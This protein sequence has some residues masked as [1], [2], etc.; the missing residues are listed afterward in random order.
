[1]GK[2]MTGAERSMSLNEYEVVLNPNDPHFNFSLQ[3]V[4]NFG[5][6]RSR[7]FRAGLFI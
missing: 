6:A 4:T 2:A 5:S 3:P 1:V 7:H